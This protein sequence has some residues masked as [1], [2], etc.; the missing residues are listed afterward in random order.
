MSQSN[1]WALTAID[2]ELVDA[3]AGR[4]PSCERAVQ[5]RVDLIADPHGEDDQGHIWTRLRAARRV[6][7]VTPG[8]VVVL[9]SAIGRYLATV[10]SWDFEVDP[11]DPI[12]VMDLLPIRPSEVERFLARNRTPAA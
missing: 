4:L 6:T 9:G 5:P 8:A 10:V 2:R 3:L 11:D 1:P 7:E 12:V